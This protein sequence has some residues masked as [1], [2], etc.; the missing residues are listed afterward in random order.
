MMEIMLTCN[1]GGRCVYN[2]PYRNRVYVL[3]GLHTYSGLFRHYA[4]QDV[5]HTAKTMQRRSLTRIGFGRSIGA[6]SDC[7]EGLGGM[8]VT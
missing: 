6:K 8:G 7:L 3:P 5:R 2:L 1:Q 4:K